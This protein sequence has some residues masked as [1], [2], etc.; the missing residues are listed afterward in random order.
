MKRILSFA[1]ALTMVLSLTACGGNDTT[2]AT[3][4]LRRTEGTVSV[5][6]GEGKGVPVLDNLGLY[7]GYGVG[8]KS[9]S[10][11]WI[12]LDDVKLAK[13]D[14]S[15]KIAIQK[16]GKALDIEVKSGSLFFNVT[17]PLADDE[18]MNISVSTMLV[19]IR[20]TCGWVESWG[21]ISR[22]YILEGKVEC[23]AGGRTVQVSAWEYAELTADG[24]LVVEPFAR[25]DIPAFVREDADPELVGGVDE[26]PEPTPEP[27]PTLTP[28]PDG[29]P[30]SYIGVTI[31]GVDYVS[32]PITL[33]YPWDE[34]VNLNGYSVL[35][36]D[37]QLTVSNL[38]NADDDCYIEIYLYKCY[39]DQDGRYEVDAGGAG[40]YLTNS[41]IFIPL[42][43]GA[44]DYGGTVELRP[45]EST[46][47]SLSQFEADPDV[48][49]FLLSPTLIYPDTEQRWPADY[50]FVD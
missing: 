49:I 7:S 16:Q 35:S 26:T 9:A 45:G 41:G 13:M 1:L 28:E 10:Y 31:V 8:T 46:A 32:E 15:S 44:E 21:N 20:G 11:A 33:Y 24:N 37:T 19:G 36:Q 29:D 3:M 42:M 12:D 39:K 30:S 43:I 22:V 14:Q 48:D 17:E 25:S 5:S 27:T 23:S 2:A 38:A 6:D 50:G 34:T 47:V 40:W 4:H 18:T